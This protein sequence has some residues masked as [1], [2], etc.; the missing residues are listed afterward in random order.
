MT[1]FRCAGSGIYVVI[2]IELWG[3]AHIELKQK[4]FHIPTKRWMYLRPMQAPIYLWSG[5]GEWS[6][7]RHCL[8]DGCDEAKTKP[9]GPAPHLPQ[10][11]IA[12]SWVH[13]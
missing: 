3:K 2:D 11:H 1:F 10:G 6:S 7:N 13:Y 5:R 8:L 12:A 9:K 4:L